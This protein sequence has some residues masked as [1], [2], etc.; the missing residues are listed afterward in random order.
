MAEME[1]LRT[2]SRT[3][4]T[5]ADPSISC[6]DGHDSARSLSGGLHDFQF[7]HL[8]RFRHF[9]VDMDCS[10]LQHRPRRWSRRE[11]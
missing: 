10:P 3:G 6:R 4:M 7:A 11:N 1:R 8:C 9:S 5:R 2:L